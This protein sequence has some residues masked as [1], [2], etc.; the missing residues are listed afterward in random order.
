MKFFTLLLFIVAFTSTSFLYAKETTATSPAQI[1]KRCA[2]CHGEDGKNPA[3]GRS[4]AI[5][6]Q[7]PVDLVES[8]NFFKES[9]FSHKDVTLVMAK[10]V[11]NLSKKQIEDLAIYISK[12]GKVK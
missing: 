2:K 9:E 4:D 6:E 1:F 3:F 10:Q 5:A 12:L 11:K 8:M 7:D